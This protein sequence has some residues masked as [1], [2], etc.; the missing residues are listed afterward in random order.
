[1]GCTCWGH[2][3]LT[4]IFCVWG[5]LKR[6]VLRIFFIG[7]GK[8]ATFFRGPPIVTNSTNIYNGGRNRNPLTNSFSTIFRSAAVNV[9]SF[10]LTRSTVLRST[11]MET[12]SGSNA[13]TDSISFVLYNSLLGRYVNDSFTI[14]SLRVPYIKLCNTY[15]AV[16]LSLTINSVLTSNNTSY[17]LTNASDRFYSDRQR[18]HCPLRCNNRHPP[19]TR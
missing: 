1:M 2:D 4:T 16:T 18:F 19:A 15:S 12:L 5:T 13:T 10:R 3:H 14:G 11:T 7:V 6:G 17:I 9:S 8:G